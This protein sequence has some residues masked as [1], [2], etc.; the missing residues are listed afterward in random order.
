MRS[1]DVNDEFSTPL[2]LCHGSNARR[3]RRC[4]PGTYPNAIASAARATGSAQA[5]SAIT[6]TAAAATKQPTRKP[7]SNR[8]EL[9]NRVNSI[10]VSEWRF[11]KTSIS[12]KTALVKLPVITAVDT[13]CGKANRSRA[14]CQAMPETEIITAMQAIKPCGLVDGLVS[15]L[16][17][18]TAASR[19]N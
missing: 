4:T 6:E 1:F 10:P 17:I 5:Q 12:D 18:R 14:Y 8:R 9:F 13:T 19:T 15:T 7:T 16:K 11:L 2:M 3:R